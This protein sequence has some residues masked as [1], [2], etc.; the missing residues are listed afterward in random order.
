MI[1]QIK[2]YTILDYTPQRDYGGGVH[3][4]SNP[5]PSIMINTTNEV[6]PIFRYININDVSTHYVFQVE[7]KMYCCLDY[8]NNWEGFYECKT[9]EERNFSAPQI[10]VEGSEVQIFADTATTHILISYYCHQQDYGH[11]FIFNFTL[12]IG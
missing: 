2:L 9:I 1:Y 6:H 4:F 7:V 5:L 3:G 8:V 10:W 11:I 12:A